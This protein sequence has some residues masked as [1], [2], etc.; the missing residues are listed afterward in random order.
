[1][2]LILSKSSCLSLIQN[3]LVEY[4]KI[5]AFVL[6]LFIE[7]EFKL[8]NFKQEFFWPVLIVDNAVGEKLILV[9]VVP[10]IWFAIVLSNKPDKQL[11]KSP[12]LSLIFSFVVH[13]Y[14]KQWLAKISFWYSLHLVFELRR[15]YWVL[16]K[17]FPIYIFQHKVFMYIINVSSLVNIHKTQKLMC[18]YW[19]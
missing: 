1:M 19:I 12:I 17:S 11:L 15:N 2:L 18:W 4:S 10:N 9:V 14:L 5:G 6:I 7:T 16:H 3:T 8:T 13:T